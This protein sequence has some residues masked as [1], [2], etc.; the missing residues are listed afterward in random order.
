M[1]KEI[2]RPRNL[3]EKIYQCPEELSPIIEK[4]KEESK[5]IVFGN[6]CFDLLHVGHINYLYEAKKQGDVLIIAI[7][8]DESISRIKPDRKLTTP[9]NERSILIASIEAVDYVIPLVEDTPISLLK[10]FKPN[11]HTKGT[12]YTPDRLPERETVQSYGGR[13][14]FVGGPKNHSTTQ[15][16]SNIRNYN[17]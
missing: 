6:G 11:I 16:I 13:I 8:T 10:I 3:I 17:K 14:M 5:T 4:F 9:Y 2:H 12:D 1:K 15:L 7:N